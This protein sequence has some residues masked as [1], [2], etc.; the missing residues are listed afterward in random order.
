MACSFSTMIDCTLGIWIDLFSLH[1]G[2]PEHWQAVEGLGERLLRRL[3]A[4]TRQQCGASVAAPSDSAPPVK[5][6]KL[7]W[8]SSR[9]EVGASAGELGLDSPGS[10]QRVESISMDALSCVE[11]DGA[12]LT[13]VKKMLSKPSESKSKLLLFLAIIFGTNGSGAGKDI[14]EAR[15]S[16]ISP[17]ED[18][19]VVHQEAES[20][21][22]RIWGTRSG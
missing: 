1:G 19:S 8:I 21:G 22:E 6:S 5:P 12:L 10:P 7:I 15:K 18:I 20:A 14:K 2:V 4:F 13:S 9:E 17:F 3:S 16:S 11:K